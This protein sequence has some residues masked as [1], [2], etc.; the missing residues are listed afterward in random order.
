[1]KAGTRIIGGVSAEFWISGFGVQPANSIK[2]TL[3]KMIQS[4]R[5]CPISDIDGRTVNGALLDL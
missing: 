3:N 4:K 1:M 5:L 2:P